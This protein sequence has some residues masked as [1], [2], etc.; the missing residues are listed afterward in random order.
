MYFRYALVL[1]AMYNGADLVSRYIPLI[2]GFIM[3]SRR[4]MMISCLARFAFIPCFYFTAKYADAG[5]MI[6]LCIMLG[7]T[8]GYLTVVVFSKAPE[9]YIVSPHNCSAFCNVFLEHKEYTK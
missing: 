4:M 6:F 3:N 9:G 7:L 8:N 5:Y 2:P 1:I